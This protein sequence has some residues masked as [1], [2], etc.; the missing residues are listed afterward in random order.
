MVV[1]IDLG[2]TTSC[3]FVP[4]HGKLE[5]IVHE[6][7]RNTIDSVIKSTPTGAAVL[8]VDN[9]ARAA[10]LEG[11]GCVYEAKRLIGRKYAEVENEVKK[12]QWPFEVFEGM[13]G[14]AAI[15][16][17]LGVFC[18]IMIPLHI[19]RGNHQTQLISTVFFFGGNKGIYSTLWNQ[20]ACSVI[21]PF[22]R[23]I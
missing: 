3:A 4:C 10:Q 13:D 14:Y 18:I 15:P 8:T 21:H 22:W 9:A 5:N 7:N 16:C 19:H 17:T 20:S 23:F 6:Q 12:N 11:K 2:M 1:G